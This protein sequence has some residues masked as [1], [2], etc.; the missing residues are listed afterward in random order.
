MNVKLIVGLGNPGQQYDKT[1]HNAGARFAEQLAAKAGVVLRSEIKF[2]GCYA[3]VTQGKNSYHL[4][5]PTTFMNHSGRSV[6]A[7]AS[8]Y[9]IPPEAILVA[10]DELDLPVGSV[11]L[12]MGGGHGG[13]NGLRDIVECLGLQ[14]FLRLRIGIGHPGHKDHV[15]DYVLGRPSFLDENK[16]QESIENAMK[17][18]PLLCEGDIS[19]AMQILHTK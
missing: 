16:I 7:C 10:H 8:F 5:I 2:H 3:Q 6:Q 1:R 4:L 14:T 9:K 18:L 17:I 15:L 13:H 11:R 19:Q 12:K